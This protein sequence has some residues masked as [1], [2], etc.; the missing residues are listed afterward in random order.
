MPSLIPVDSI[1]ALIAEIPRWADRGND[2]MNK[3]PPD[4]P[5]ES[6]IVLAQANAGPSTI[7]AP[8]ALARLPASQAL[9]GAPPTNSYTAAT[10]ALAL[11]SEERALYMRHLQNLYGS[12]GVDNPD[13]SRSS[14]L[15]MN[16]GLGDRAYNLPTVYDGQALEPE[17]AIDRARQQGLNI[18]PSYASPF[19]AEN[20]YQR[21][22]NYM[23]KDTGEFLR[24][25]KR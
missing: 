18:F 8:D 4:A 2:P 12:G 16:V 24:S 17:P 14:L 25:R 1:R 9:P 22:H 6:P 23:D 21:M 10:N 19:E 11:N 20:R 7:P 5:P 3:A 13:G 15:Q